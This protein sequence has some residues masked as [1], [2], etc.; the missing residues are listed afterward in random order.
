MIKLISHLIGDVFGLFHSVFTDKASATIKD[1]IV[2][3]VGYVSA[4][5]YLQAARYIVDCVKDAKN[6]DIDD[7]VLEAEKV[8]LD[9]KELMKVIDSIRASLVPSTTARLN[10]YGPEQ[11]AIQ[12][13]EDAMTYG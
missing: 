7:I 9:L 12:T 10:P 8:S 11:K 5:N 13:L 2:T 6:L 4:K 3:F 1:E